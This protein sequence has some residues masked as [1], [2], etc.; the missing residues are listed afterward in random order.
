MVVECLAVVLLILVFV[1]MA[2]RRGAKR[3]ALMTLPLVCVPLVH[4][5]FTPFSVQIARWIPGVGPELFAIGIDLL[6][7]VATCVMLGVNA[8]HMQSQ[9][10]R[11]TYMLLCSGFSLI[12][13][14][15]LV[16]GIIQPFLP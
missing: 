5:L 14:L 16:N 7:L 10:L 6:G 2:Y 9:R 15:I 8:F 4:I 13:C 1:T 12:F 3:A 11:R